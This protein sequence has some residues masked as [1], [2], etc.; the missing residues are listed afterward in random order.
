M[1]LTEVIKPREKGRKE[2][3]KKGGRKYKPILDEALTEVVES[4]KKYF[5]LELHAFATILI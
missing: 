4:E 3:R 5:R 1:Q 2:E